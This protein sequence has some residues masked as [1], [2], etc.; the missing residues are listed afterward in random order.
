MASLVIDMSKVFEGY[1]RAVLRSGLAGFDLQALDGNSMGPGFGG[2]LLFDGTPS[3]EANPDVVIRPKSSEATRLVADAKYKPV[4]AASDRDDINQVIVY[5][6]SYRCPRVV[7]VHP[8]PIGRSSGLR[9][10]GTIGTLQVYQYML[11]LGAA[12]LASEERQFVEAIAAL[13]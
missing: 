5:G 2:K 12:D 10:L 13:S 3:E 8:C 6:A 9:Q 7:L 4:T 1:I 11:E